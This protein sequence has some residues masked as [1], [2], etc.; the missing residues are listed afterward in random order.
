MN[1]VF[2]YIE[3]NK[4]R[5]LAE[6]FTF[7]RQPSISAQ[8]TGVSEC[9]ALLADLMRQSGIETAIYPTARHPVV[10]GEV[11]G[12]AGAPTIL[13]YGHYD[14]QPPE[15]F[16]QWQSDPFEPVIRDGKIY[17]RGSSDDKSQLFAHVKGLEAWRKVRGELPVTIKYIFEG[18]EEIGSPNLAPFAESHQ[19]L[20]KSDVAVFS[21]S[22]IHE[23]GRQ[24]L[25]LGLK[26][27]TYVWITLKGANRD[28]RS[29]KAPT[30]PNPVWRMIGLLNTL[31]GEDGL[32]RIEG[33]YDDVRPLLP[34]EMEAVSKIPLDAAAIRQDLGIQTL[35]TNRTGDHYYYNL[36]FEPTCNIAGIYGGYTGKGSKT[37]IP[38]TVSVK[39][40]MRLVPD[41]K[42]Q[43]I[44]AKLQRHLEKHG[45]GDAE[46]SSHGMIKPSRTPIDNPYVSLVE[47]AV[48]E[49][50]GEAPLVFPGIGGAGPNYVFTD[51]LGIPCIVVPFAASDQ[52]N[53]AP[54]ENMIVHG[55]INGIKTSA[56]VIEKIGRAGGKQNG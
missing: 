44:L 52:N 41:Q 20:L 22:H 5:Y 50:W 18:E 14:V 23:P 7:L 38:S 49:A 28:V 56:A 12:P 45:Y 26:G 19:E 17:A 54:N 24:M 3:A 25:I 35:L 42:P 53:H 47:A 27:M 21:D 32:V 10:C 36:I 16:E 15:P 30:V 29:M 46:I 2:A 13:V 31:K 8:N 51:I 9:A 39:I 40:D 34:L 55:Y 48:K 1:D 11:K 4:E 37:I 43:D 33:F 6:L